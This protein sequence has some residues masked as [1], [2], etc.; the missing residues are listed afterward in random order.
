MM[1]AD[2]LQFQELP[3]AKLE[4]GCCT[5][6]RKSKDPTKSSW[7]ELKLNKHVTQCQETSKTFFW[8][9]DFED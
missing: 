9:I 2:T 4:P 5:K 6:R 1:L 7:S 8:F 3:S